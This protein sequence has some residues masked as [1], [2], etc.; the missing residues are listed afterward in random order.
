MS[1]YVLGVAPSS[2]PDVSSTVGSAV[3][4]YSQRQQQM[5]NNRSYHHA[6]AAGSPQPMPKQ[7]TKVRL[8]LPKNVVLLSLMEATDF[9][10]ETAARASQ[11][12]GDDGSSPS[13]TGVRW[14]EQESGDMELCRD[15][16][17]MKT[18]SST[19]G[20]FQMQQRRIIPAEEDD[21]AN[22]EE[23]Q[24]Q[25]I[26]L[27]TSIV[28]SACGT[29]AVA[30]KNGLI[31]VPNRP[32]VAGEATATTNS[33]SSSA[34][35]KKTPKFKRTVS[36]T[37][38]RDVSSMI[39]KVGNTRTGMSEE[40]QGHHDLDDEFIAET[41]TNNRRNAIVEDE[42]WESI[43]DDSK[44]EPGPMKLCYGDR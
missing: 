11:C 12:G 3:P 6:T 26:K 4:L 1:L 8:P 5:R 14:E 37:W 18:S 43:T 33:S 17:P 36:N 13:S 16:V 34:S 24:E 31:I 29:Y 40:P 21:D 19:Q 28:T 25:K 39:H 2:P 15:S 38:E 7:Q 42:S 30:C 23:R 22:E 32:D 10:S 41:T 35:V 44:A 9:A 27:S 20:L